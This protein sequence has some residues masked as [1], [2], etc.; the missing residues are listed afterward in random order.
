MRVLIRRLGVV[1]VCTAVCALVFPLNASAEQSPIVTGAGSTWSQIAV[2][3]WRADVSRFGLRINYQG[4]GSSAG[5]SFYVQNQVDFAVSEIPFESSEIDA[6]KSKGKT[7]VYLPIVAGGTSLMYNLKDR[8]GKA[9]TTLKLSSATVTGIFTGKITN[10]SDPGLRADNPGLSLPDQRIVPVIRSDGSGTTAQ[11][12]AYM[13][14]RESQKWCDFA[15]EH[16]YA[17]TYT[18]NY[19]N[20]PGSVAQSGSDGVANYVHGESTGQGAITY[21]ETGYALQRGRPVA[22]LK[23]ASGNFTLPTSKNVST[24]LTK[25]T[26]NADR[27]QNLDQVYVHPARNAYA[28]S[29]YSYMI[30]PSAN[31]PADKG[32]VLG[33]FMIYFACEGQRKA[34]L[35]GYSPLPKN[36]V[37]VVFDAVRKVPGAPSPPAIKDCDNPTINGDGGTSDGTAGALS[38]GKSTTGSAP[39]PNA[40]GA[41][42]SPVGGQAATAAGG[43]AAA[44]G[45]AS[46]SRGA[47]A[48]APTTAAGDG[49]LP[50]GADGT[51]LPG[52]AGGS[53]VQALSAAELE[54]ASASSLP[55]AVAAIFVGLLVFGPP[56]FANVASWRRRVIEELR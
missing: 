26:L 40:A 20:F 31:F 9:I 3:Q 29:S 46:T 45:S 23:N 12:T 53:S 39:A 33:K 50:V 11:F 5:R 28:M 47:A 44:G 15:K 17:C 7:W 24:A 55:L 51:P 6:L 10:W 30:V 27:T 1:A 34:D 49:A 4:V 43:A 25:A 8:A 54:E 32:E 37:E 36:L 22:F 38:G 52:Y 13:A 2:D 35:L 14:K 21:V 16:G 48:S 19:P 42:G 18:S 56:L 41:A